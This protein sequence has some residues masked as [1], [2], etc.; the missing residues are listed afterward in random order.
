MLSR[1]ARRSGRIAR[2]DGLGKHAVFINGGA[3]AFGLQQGR[4]AKVRRHDI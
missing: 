3:L 4:S 2:R 1:R